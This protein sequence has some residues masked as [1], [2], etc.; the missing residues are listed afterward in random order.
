MKR[1]DLKKRIDL[2]A[3][4]HLPKEQRVWLDGHAYIQD[5][6]R[7]IKAMFAPI[8][9]GHATI[10]SFETDA[11]RAAYLGKNM[12]PESPGQYGNSEAYRSFVAIGTRTIQGI[13][14]T[15]KNWSLKT[16]SVCATHAR[17]AAES[18]TSRAQGNTVSN[19]VPTI[20]C[21]PSEAPRV[22]TREKGGLVYISVNWVRSVGNEGIGVLEH[23]TRNPDKILV[24]KAKHNPSVFLA[25]MGVK[26]FE[27]QG[28][29]LGIKAYEVNGYAFTMVINDKRHSIFHENFQ[30]GVTQMQNLIAE[31]FSE[32]MEVP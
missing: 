14:G 26:C 22:V 10:M 28:M 3:Y 23:G 19:A 30:R 29:R 8:D 16:L 2:K 13:R 31:A 32:A 21:M 25:E 7:S 18:A 5:F 1:K 4:A 17:R 11:L 20:R 15:R 24:V 27:V 12:Y 9:G 6:N